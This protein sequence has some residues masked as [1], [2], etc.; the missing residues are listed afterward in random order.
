[1]S[2][3]TGAPAQGAPTTEPQTQPNQPGEPATAEPLG[4]GGIKALQ[5]ER[6]ARAA[7][8]KSAAA[9]Q[10]QLNEIAKANMSELEK[11][12]QAAKESQE[13]AA[14]ATTE[15]MRYR[16][17]AA[18]GISTV[19]GEDGSPSDAEVFLTAADEAGMTAQ[20]QRFAARTAQQ[21]TA[22]TFPRPD[23]TQGSGRDT[24]NAPSPGADFQKFL[25]SQ[26][27]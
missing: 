12:Q 6:A 21:G 20:A 22:P 11:A 15:A 5:D 23:L 19:P 10:A 9:L 18:N 4:A 14:K 27:G 25:N 17:A 2:E 8:E 26:L 13:A 1:M 7:A 3:P 24:A 16:L